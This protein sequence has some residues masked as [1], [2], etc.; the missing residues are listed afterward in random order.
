MTYRR[1]HARYTRRV[2]APRI[3]RDI[4]LPIDPN[5]PRRAT[6]RRLA[7]VDALNPSLLYFAVKS[8]YEVFA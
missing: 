1:P 5:A 2:T 7:A 8:R 3:N 6:L 4:R